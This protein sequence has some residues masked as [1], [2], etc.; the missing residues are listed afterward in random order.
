MLE[1]SKTVGFKAILC[2][3]SA[4]N[5][6]WMNFL[7]VQKLNDNSLLRAHGKRQ[8]VKRTCPSAQ[9]ERLLSERR[10]NTFTFKLFVHLFL[11]DNDKKMDTVDSQILDGGP[12]QRLIGPLYSHFAA[13]RRDSLSMPDFRYTVSLFNRRSPCCSGDYLFFSREVSR[14][15]KSP[16]RGDCD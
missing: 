12:P 1:A 15:P 3:K 13:D 7:I 16:A 8:N 2:C 11:R 5:L 9:G 10:V 4:V 6:G 14:R